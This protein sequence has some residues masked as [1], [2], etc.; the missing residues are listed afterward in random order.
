MMVKETYIMFTG[1]DV[2]GVR[3]RCN[4]H[5]CGRETLFP[6]NT[7]VYVPPHCP[8]CRFEWNVDVESFRHLSDLL[9]ALHFFRDPNQG[10]LGVVF[11]MKVDE[12]QI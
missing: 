8:H 9:A 3:V 4:S 5:N 10:M 7:G 12:N 6:F 2:T 1:G 11:E